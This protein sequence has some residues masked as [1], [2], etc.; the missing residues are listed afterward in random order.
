MLVESI[1]LINCRL[2][3]L[4]PFSSISFISKFVAFVI[5]ISALFREV[6]AMSCYILNLTISSVINYHYFLNQPLISTCL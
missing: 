6:D 5:S 2:E 4:K 3:K 1:I